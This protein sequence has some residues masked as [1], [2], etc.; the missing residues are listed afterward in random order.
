VNSAYD[1]SVSAGNTQSYSADDTD[2][3]EATNTG[4]SVSN[5]TVH[6]PSSDLPVRIYTPGG[7]GPFPMLVFFGGWWL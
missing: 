6:G 2:E 1:H 5:H 4:A 3:H 7:I